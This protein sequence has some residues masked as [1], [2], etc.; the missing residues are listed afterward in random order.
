MDT[1]A[2]SRAVN[3][4][5]ASP[6]ALLALS[7]LGQIALHG[8]QFEGQSRRLKLGDGL[9]KV[10]QCRCHVAAVAAEQTPRDLRTCGLQQNLA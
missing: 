8:F 7:H 5:H 10:S 2:S 1:S 6:Y 9:L 4:F 3:F